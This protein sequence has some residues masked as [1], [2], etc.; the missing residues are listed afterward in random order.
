MSDVIDVEIIDDFDVTLE[1]SSSVVYVGGGSGPGEGYLSY[2]TTQAL[3]LAELRRVRSNQLIGS[4]PTVAYTEG[5]L[6]SITYQDGSVKTFTYT[7]GLLTRVDYAIGI[8]VYRKDLAYT[9]GTL[10]NVSEVII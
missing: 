2:A 3:T 4:A 8:R 9:N 5:V 1:L 10:T 6:A 7:D